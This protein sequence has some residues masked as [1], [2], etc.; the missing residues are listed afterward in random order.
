[1]RLAIVT[2]LVVSAAAVVPREGR[3]LGR[4]QGRVEALAC[5]PTDAEVAAAIV[6]GT[7]WVTLDGGAAWRSVRRVASLLDADPGAASGDAIEATE[8]TETSEEIEV[9]TAAADPPIALAVGDRGEWA[10]A[11]GSRWIFDLGAGP[12]IRDERSAVV[13]GLAIDSAARL[14]V[15]ASD[16]VE[17]IA[18]G[19][20]IEAIANAGS[21]APVY[22]AGPGA[23]VVP[24]ALGIAE[25]SMGSGGELTER[26][27]GP[28]AEAVAVDAIGGAVY[29]VRQGAISRVGDG[30]RTSFAARAPARARRLVT[31][32]SAFWVLADGRWHTSGFRGAPRPEPAT[33]VCADA[34]GRL[35]RG[36]E[37]GPIAPAESVAELPRPELPI[38]GG[39]TPIEPDRRPPPPCP[40]P[41]AALLPAAALSFGFGLGE[42]ATL[43]ADGMTDTAG[44][45]SWLAIGLTLTWDLAPA[46]DGR[47]EASRERFAERKADR[48]IRGVRLDADLA[49]AVAAKAGARTIE[50]A[51]QATIAVDETRARI[52][53]AGGRAPDDEEERR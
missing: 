16:R 11:S 10:I 17:V 51:L 32:G 41:A 50:E 45:R 9:S 36:S 46:V 27:V 6:D 24:G 34:Q 14:W 1:V 37:R 26:V 30:G 40:R 15:A 7:L 49:S 23:I 33:A 53:A 39:S 35:W 22:R 25:L 5:A 52:A 31:A 13:A 8:E 42:V 12:V 48:L 4:P 3:A 2:A 47:C 44:S 29:A 43:T 28:P 21:G 19:R 20:T 38:D 18:N